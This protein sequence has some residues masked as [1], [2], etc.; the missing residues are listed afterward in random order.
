MERLF[1]QLSGFGNS[2]QKQHFFNR[3][4]LFFWIAFLLSLS[5]CT[6]VPPVSQQPTNYDVA[7]QAQAEPLRSGDNLTLF[8]QWWKPASEP[9][10][11]LLLVHGTYVHS[12][13]YSEWANFLTQHEYA[14]YGF[15]L[16]GWGQS[17]GYGR[18]GY[19]EKFEQYAD[20]VAQACELVK[21]RYPN[22]PLF[23]QGESLGGLVVLLTQVKERCRAEGLVLNAPAVRPALSVGYLQA[24]YWLA[25][26][27][28]WA[29][30]FPGQVF[31]NQPL[32]PGAVVELFA[33][34][35]VESDTLVKN[36]KSDPHVVHS[37]LPMGFIS[38]LQDGTTQV[39]RGLG[40]I[41]L[42]MLVVHGGKDTLVPVS[43][44]EYVLK[45]SASQDKT[46]KVYWEMSH[47]TLHDIGHDAV[48]GDILQWLDDRAVVKRRF[49]H[50]P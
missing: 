4:R 30:S 1:R 37:G 44:S 50:Q 26:F 43:S 47:A 46:L 36:F 23:V 12:G 20:D 28:L 25:D 38:A 16:R 13:F 19:V 21:Q 39:E 5:A 6:S 42:P 3:M 9:K 41:T 7:P 32:M 27:S 31:P 14:V 35:A 24:P 29:A 10:A 48:W 2:S 34:M 8:G 11:V 17:Q 15:D 40:H 18:R 45:K 33:G 22:T 49:A